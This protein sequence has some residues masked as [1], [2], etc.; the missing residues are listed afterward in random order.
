MRDVPWIA[1]WMIV[2][3]CRSEDSEPVALEQAEVS[4]ARAR[5]TTSDDKNLG[6]LLAEIVDSRACQ[7]LRNTYRALHGVQNP[8]VVAGTLW[9][10]ECAIESAGTNVTVRLAGDGWE[11][12]HQKK[13]EAEAHFAV[14]QYRSEEHTSELQSRFDLV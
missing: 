9:I 8:D 10:R 5:V 1:T 4:P 13:E 7:D 11:W 6:V 14:Q 2:L 3:A 12:L